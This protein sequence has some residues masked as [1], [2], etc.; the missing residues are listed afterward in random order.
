M[1]RPS[2]P[3]I[4]AL[5]WG[6]TEAW[7]WPPA[8]ATARSTTV[9]TSPLASCSGTGGFNTARGTI[10]APGRGVARKRGLNRAITDKGWHGLELALTSAARST[11]TQ[12]IKVNPAYTSIMCS[13]C[14]HVDLKSRESQAVF[15][16]TGCGL[17]VHAD[18]NAAV[19]I[20]HAGGQ[21]VS[22]RG[23]LAAGRSV[24]RQP[25][26]SRARQHASLV[27]RGIPVL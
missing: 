5:R 8:Q 16:C 26:Q 13:A 18:V 15:R 9:P 12:I 3:R 7:S 10:E 22:G 25:P 21:S 17:V 14:A 20:K 23:D 1:G 4:P 6:S 24:K 19:N 11:G 2:R 27:T